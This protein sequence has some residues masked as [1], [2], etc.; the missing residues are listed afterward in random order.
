VRNRRPVAAEQPAR[1]GE[2]QP[3]HDVGEI[4]GNLAG[5]GDLGAP[6]RDAPQILLADAEHL[7]HG[8]LD[9]LARGVN[10]AVVVACCEGELAV[11]GARGAMGAVFDLQHRR[12]SE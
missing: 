1:V 2:R 5:K 3:A 12:K 4:H 6:P 7:H 11:G 10:A 9:G 8:L